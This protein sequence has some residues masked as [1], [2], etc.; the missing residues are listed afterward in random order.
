MPVQVLFKLELGRITS[1][2]EDFIEESEFDS[3]NDMVGFA[4][5]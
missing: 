5:K 3:I 2:L 1:D 4:H